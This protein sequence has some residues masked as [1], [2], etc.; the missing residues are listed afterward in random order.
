MLRLQTSIGA[1]RFPSIP[2][3]QMRLS[4]ASA[5]VNGTAINGVAPIRN[6]SANYDIDD[7][8]TVLSWEKP[9]DLPSNW[10]TQ[11]GKPA[12]YMGNW[13]EKG[14]YRM[15]IVN[16]W[17]AEELQKLGLDG[18]KITDIAFVPATERATYYPLVFTGGDSIKAGSEDQSVN[19]NHPG[20]DL[21]IGEWNEI[22]LPSPHVIDA[23]QELCFGVMTFYDGTKDAIGFDN[24]PMKTDRNL[25][26][27]DSF[28]WYRTSD[29]V[30][31]VKGNPCLAANIEFPNGRMGVMSVRANRGE[32]S[33]EVYCDST[34]LGTTA[35][36]QY[37]VS[38][39]P[40]DN[41]K[42]SVIANHI[43]KGK[44]DA[45]STT[46]FAGNPCPAPKT[47]SADV[48]NGD[49]KLNWQTSA[50]Y[51]QPTNLLTEGFEDGIP[52]TWTRLKNDIDS[53]GW[54]SSDEY[55]SGAYS[56]HPKSGRFCALSIVQYLDNNW[57]TTLF[58][59]DNWL[60]T[61]KLHL[62]EGYKLSYQISNLYCWS[63]S[64][65]YEVLV[66][67]TGTERD[68]FQVVYSD[69][70]PQNNVDVWYA[71]TLDLSD[72]AGKD[73]YIAFR[74][75]NSADD[76]CVGLQL[77]DISVD[78]FTPIGR[79]YNVYRDGELIAENVCDSSYVDIDCPAGA[80]T[81][82]ITA[83]CDELTC[84]SN[85]SSVS[86]DI[87]VD[88]INNVRTESTS[89]YYNPINATIVVSRNGLTVGPVDVYDIAGHVVAHA[90]GDTDRVIIL[91]NDFAPNVY[92]VKGAG[93][94]A[95]ITIK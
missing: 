43:D 92:V 95:K 49:V 72:Y 51:Q 15:F 80:H 82:T 42:F 87:T 48:E 34:L 68:D 11:S 45:V 50:P 23:S 60:I 81:W 90:D 36:T 29:L 17:T 66:S 25:I 71:K 38:N 74:H 85:P 62:T 3:M 76:V 32:I 69:T 16:R 6:L 93:K 94:A 70:L 33:Y 20:Y 46:F 22:H 2:T 83:I 13:N 7:K 65:Y 12:Q 18:A 10:I 31:E 61:P 79:H 59:P 26:S 75:H 9:G 40:E 57:Q 39:L 1:P 54:M 37:E 47:V 56:A 35:D 84:E 8:T 91:A 5:N 21:N 77:D 78:G 53:I 24:D 88:G 89:I 73:V 19:G 67:T 44:S 28:E 63:M 41:Y 55:T 4:S 58:S 27:F 30:P 14:M 86:A 52:D 64:T